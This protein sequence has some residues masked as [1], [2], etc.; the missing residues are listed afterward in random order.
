MLQMVNRTQRRGAEVFALELSRA[1]EDRGH[2]TRVV[3]LYGPADGPLALRP[4]DVALEGTASHPLE[5]AFHPKLLRRL[6]SAVTSFRPHVVQVNGSRTVK[7]G[8]LLRRLR[9]RAP[10]VLVYRSIGTPSAWLRGPLHRTLYRHLVLSAMDGV[11][12][13]SGPTRADL[14]RS[15]DLPVPLAV[16]PRGVDVNALAEPGTGPSPRQALGTPQHRPVLL[17][18]GSLTREKRPDRL[19]RVAAAAARQLAGG[20]VSSGPAAELWVVGEGPLCRQLRESPG[21]PSLAVH[22]V[23]G[24]E[25]VTPWLHA[26]DLLLLTSDTEGTPGAVLEAAAA[27]LPAV[28][29]RV[30]GVAECV[31][32]GRSGLLAEASDEAGLVA[33]VLELLRDPERRRRM[34]RE[35]RRKVRSEFA[36]DQIAGRYENFYRTLWH[37]RNGGKARP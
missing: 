18:V 34:G 6:V 10:W 37:G 13:L 35:A 29:T 17:Y 7:Y 26:A 23:G 31:E 24:Q 28:A 16:L 2:L 5:R 3:A 33:A 1:L 36:L 22:L 30:G 4:G 15:Y 8:S 21:E 19:L 12:A 27:G 9:P 14:E 32:D 11:V 20:E 25:D